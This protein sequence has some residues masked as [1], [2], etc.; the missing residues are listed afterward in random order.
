MSEN[1]VLRR[2][3]KPKRNT[4]TGGAYN[5]FYSPHSRMIKSWRL[6]WGAACSAQGEDEECLQ[7]WDGKPEG[8]RPL[9][10]PRK[11]MLK[12]ILKKGWRVWT[13]FIWLGIGTIGRL[14]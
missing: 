11:I 10:R 4:V 13:G 3:F 14:L 5:F 9:G 1:R 2:I 6:R 12:W 7:T 8:K